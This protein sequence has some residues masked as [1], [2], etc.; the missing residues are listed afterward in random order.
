MRT[1]ICYWC[2]K[3]TTLGMHKAC[4]RDLTCFALNEHRD[5]PDLVNDPRLIDELPHYN[6]AGYRMEQGRV[7]P[8]SLGE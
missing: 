6:R 7:M 2:G 5:L 3:L 4:W 8:L 1:N